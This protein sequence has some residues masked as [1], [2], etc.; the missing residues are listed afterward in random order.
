M[1]PKISCNSWLFDV[2]VQ[3]MNSGHQHRS[4][5]PRWHRAA[6]CH[7]S[8]DTTQSR[9]EMTGEVDP[10]VSYGRA[11]A[12]PSQSHTNL[13]QICPTS[14]ALR[15]RTVWT[16]QFDMDDFGLVEHYRH[17]TAMQESA[18]HVW[19]PVSK[20]WGV[21]GRKKNCILIIIIIYRER[22]IFKSYSNKII[23]VHYRSLIQEYI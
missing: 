9:H 5:R 4:N 10:P 15:S 1:S 7:P 13:T 6:C 12:G 14:D 21:H 11:S 3:L 22:Y 23:V 19:R 8:V 18:N 2:K 17:V 20:W 16:I